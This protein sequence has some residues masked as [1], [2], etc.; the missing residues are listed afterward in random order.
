MFS[1]I[2][3]VILVFGFVGLSLIVFFLIALGKD[4]L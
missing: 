1:L 3:T 4:V 2:S